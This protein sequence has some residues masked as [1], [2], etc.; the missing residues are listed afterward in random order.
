MAYKMLEGAF[1]NKIVFSSDY[2]E[3]IFAAKD[4]DVSIG[5][6]TDSPK[7]QLVLSIGVYKTPETFFNEVFSTD[8]LGHN[9]RDFSELEFDPYIHCLIDFIGKNKIL[10]TFIDRHIDD[11]YRQFTD[12]EMAKF[13]THQRVGAKKNTDIFFIDTKAFLK[14][15]KDVLNSKIKIRK[16]KLIKNIQDDANLQHIRTYKKRDEIV[17]DGWEIIKNTDLL[18]FQIELKF[19][20]M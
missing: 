10:I 9:R 12:P 13:F 14:I 2:R 18:F 16:I 20:L 5:Y 8:E 6:R 15:F 3:V 4:L 11:E 1:E 7:K 17:E 19:K